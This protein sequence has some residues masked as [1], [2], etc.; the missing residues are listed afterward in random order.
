MPT[1]REFITKTV[2][3]AS[4]LPFSAY[5]FNNSIFEQQDDVLNVNIFSKH[6]QFLDYKSTGE[7]VAEM[8]FSGVDLT[9]RPNGHVLPESVKTDL[10]KAVKAITASG[11]NCSMITTSIES[12][13]NPLDVDIL[14]TAGSENIQYY[15]TNWYKYKENM[16]MQ[17]SLL[18][19][20]NE[21]KQL[22]DLNE[23][24]GLIGCYQ[25]HAGTSVGAS[26]WEIQKILE[27]VNPKHFGTQ[28]DIRH[29][30]V[31]G[32]KSWENG[33]QLLQKNIKVIV[34]KDFKWGQVNGKWEPINV[35]I[36]EGMVDFDKYFKLLKKHNLK[37]P[38]S[39]HLEYDLGGAE[40]GDYE[41]TVDKKVVFDAMKRDL[42]KVQQLWKNA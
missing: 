7:I 39:L 20:Q 33:F 6:L 15:R 35:P 10:P 23:K 31:E 13:N 42:K 26:Y 30:M 18:F 41:I 36:G 2:C 12:V 27:T 9:V 28:Y 3:A 5:A 29:A 11:V 1:R 8:G 40:K 22:G 14:K 16:S 24:L 34:L 32:G 19:Y 21:V 38:V 17:D 25:N 4:L 37:P